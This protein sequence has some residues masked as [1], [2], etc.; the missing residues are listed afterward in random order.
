MDAVAAIAGRV[1]TELA[2]SAEHDLRCSVQTAALGEHP[3]GSAG[4]ARR[5]LLVEL[6]LPWPKK[7]DQHDLLAHTD[8]SADKDVKLLGI[9]S[10][11]ST[12]LERHRV[13]CWE[14][15]EP[16][17]GYDRTETI[18]DRSALEATLQSIADTGPSAI[19]EPVTVDPQTQDLLICTHGTRDR[20]CGQLGMR[21]HTDLDCAFG[22]NVRMWRTSHTGGHRFAPT[23]IHFPH[24]TT[25][26][27]LSPELTVAIVEQT[28]PTNR[29]SQH[30]RG[31][32]GVKGRPAQIAEGATFLDQGW[33][34]LDNERTVEI[35]TGAATGSEG[36]NT[37]VVDVTVGGV[38]VMATVRS[39]DH[40]A[41][42]TMREHDAIPVPACGE[43]IEAATKATPQF[44]IV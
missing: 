28:L 24:G 10:S 6:P 31:N 33:S 20:C 25:W 9:R 37:P 18:V 5:V 44:R 38:T 19:T 8:L 3:A 39:A 12:E 35:E 21:L 13:I 30:Y 16:F 36:G 29:L 34:W 15:T 32:L 17:R 41:V 26:S 11:E 7:I 23:G 43:D 42:V 22:P 14:R 27:S 40:S 2:V 4:F 1:M